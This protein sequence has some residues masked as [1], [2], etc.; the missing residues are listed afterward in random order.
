MIS[1]TMNNEEMELLNYKLGV[2]HKGCR[3]KGRGLVKSDACGQGEGLKANLQ[4]SAEFEKT[5]KLKRI[6]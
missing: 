3:H 5:V 1:L 4:M 6:Y 2:I